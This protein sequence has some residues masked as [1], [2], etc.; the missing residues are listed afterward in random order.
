MDSIKNQ[1][2]TVFNNSIGS[3]EKF[4]VRHEIGREL[5]TFIEKGDMVQI[6]IGD[7]GGNRAMY[8]VFAPGGGCTGPQK[9]GDP[10]GFEG[11]GATVKYGVFTPGGGCVGP[12]KPGNPVGSEGPGAT[13]KYGVFTPE[14]PIEGPQQPSDPIGP[15][16]TVKYGVFTPGGGCEGPQQPGDP[17]GPQGPGATVKYGVFTPGGGCGGENK[18][19]DPFA[20]MNE[21]MRSQMQAMIDQM[22]SS[23]E[24]L[25]NAKDGKYTNEQLQEIAQQGG[26]TGMYAQAVL[27]MQQFDGDLSMLVVPPA[28]DFTGYSAPNDGIYSG[29]MAPQAPAAQQPSQSPF[30][31]PN[32][33][34]SQY[35]ADLMN[36]LAANPTTSTTNMAGMP[37]MDWST[38]QAQLLQQNNAEKKLF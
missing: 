22:N 34:W 14:H 35:Q 21:T 15:G 8:G 20:G 19:I 5:P 18:P 16:A 27:Q 10:I 3:I 30:A 32:L 12:E 13:V 37:S 24:F 31:L 33:N 38:L 23:R 4:N 11:P 26:M 2:S 28:V 6:S 36:Q 25:Q 17:V 9:P 1:L 7:V 29:T